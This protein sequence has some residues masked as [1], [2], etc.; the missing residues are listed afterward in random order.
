[1]VLVVYSCSYCKPVGVTVDRRYVVIFLCS[2]K[3]SF[4]NILNLLKCLS[5]CIR[6]IRQEINP[7]RKAAANKNMNTFG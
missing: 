1:M 5:F 7:M 4:G 3:N 2:G 6:K